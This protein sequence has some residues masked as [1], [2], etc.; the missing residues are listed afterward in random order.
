LLSAVGIPL[1]GSQTAKIIAQHYGD[2]E[3]LKNAKAEDLLKIDTVGEE[4]AK[5]TVEFFE[6][7]NNRRLFEKFREYGLSLKEEFVQNSGKLKGKTVVLTGTLSKFTRDEATEILEKNGAKVAGSVSKK[8]ALVI[9][10]ENAG[11]KLS[12]AEELGIEVKG[13]EFLENLE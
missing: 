13:E 9:A 2:Y 1:V 10:G 4:I 11:S 5:S 3:N 6:D 12:K 7:E 8:T